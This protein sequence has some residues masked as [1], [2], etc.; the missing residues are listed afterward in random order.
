[1]AFPC[2]FPLWPTRLLCLWVRRA[3]RRK[4]ASIF[5]ILMG[6]ALHSVALL[7]VSG[8]LVHS[9]CLPVHYTKNK[10]EA[11]PMLQVRYG[12]WF[13]FSQN[14]AVIFSQELQRFL[15][16]LL[17]PPIATFCILSTPGPWML[18]GMVWREGQHCAL[19]AL[20]RAK[21]LSV[22]CTYLHSLDEVGSVHFSVWFDTVWYILW[23]SRTLN[24]LWILYHTKQRTV[25]NW[26]S[27]EETSWC[28]FFQG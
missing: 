12:M 28:F 18:G 3:E 7:T 20:S 26:G 2:S 24:T 19:M 11:E 9:S 5:G 25:R 8:A 17:L 23:L 15:S 6:C 22:V 27:E 13:W 14:S 10:W 21:T 16:S 1:M 4:E